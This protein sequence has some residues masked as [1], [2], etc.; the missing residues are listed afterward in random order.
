MKGVETRE[1]NAYI[2]DVPG[3]IRHDSFRTSGLNVLF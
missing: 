2:E 3:R 1:R